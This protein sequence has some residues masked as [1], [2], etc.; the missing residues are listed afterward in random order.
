MKASL[1]LGNCHPYKISDVLKMQP[2]I[3]PPIYP[4]TG[5]RRAE[6]LC[7]ITSYFNVCGY[8]ALYENYIAF[9]KSMQDSNIPLLTIECAF[10][11]SPFQL[12]KEDNVVQVRSNSIMWQKERLLNI[13]L[14]KVRHRFAKVAWIDADT[15]FSNSQWAIETSRLL[16]EMPIVQPYDTVILLPKDANHFDGAGA[17]RISFAFDAAVNGVASVRNSA[18]KHGHTGYAWAARTEVLEHGLFDAAIANGGDHMMAHALLDDCNS[19]CYRQLFFDD[20]KSRAY[21]QT[22]ANSIIPKVHKG[23]GYVPGAVLHLWHGSM[24]NRRYHATL[25]RLA[26]FGMDPNVDLKINEQGCWEW[27]SKRPRLHA[28]AAS[29]FEQRQD[30]ED[31]LSTVVHGT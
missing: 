9:K 25:E 5:Y 26:R 13:A 30:D 2:T 18:G 12:E 10:N 20:E 24:R 31:S 16:D 4:A 22:W 27:N 21:F 8:R 3:T 11:D 17:H 7:V 15:F 6:D 28:F 1:K 19:P 29:Y 14:D 23:V